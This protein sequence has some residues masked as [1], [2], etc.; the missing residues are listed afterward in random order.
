MATENNNINKPTRKRKKAAQQTE[1][2]QSDAPNLTPMGV[3]LAQNADDVA[4]ADG[5]KASREWDP[6]MGARQDSPKRDYVPAQPSESNTTDVSNQSSMPGSN[7]A[8]VPQ[9]SDGTYND[10]P[11]DRSGAADAVTQPDQGVEKSDGKISE[12]LG[13]ISQGGDVA[14][15]KKAEVSLSSVPSNDAKLRQCHRHGL[16]C[17]GICFHMIR[18]SI[19]DSRHMD[20]LPRAINSTV[21]IEMSILPT[22]VILIEME[23]VRGTRLRACLVLKG[24][25]KYLMSS[26]LCKPVRNLALSIRLQNYWFLILFII[27]I[28]IRCDPNF[29]AFHRL[30]RLS[31]H[32]NITHNG[33]W[34]TDS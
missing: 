6:H 10:E 8:G 9:R 19:D 16:I 26:L 5:A 11:S 33:L 29:R 23:I 20:S 21:G 2:Q 34:V 22:V 25:G 1:Q 28:I 13:T 17:H 4:T 24:I 30:P 7:G 3:E 32:Y 27:I 18:Q 14:E 15:D 12:N 31:V